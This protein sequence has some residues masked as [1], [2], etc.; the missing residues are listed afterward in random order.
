MN[1]WSSG[2]RNIINRVK[3]QVIDVMPSATLKE[4]ES[5]IS[6]FK[7]IDEILARPAENRILMGNSCQ[8]FV[9]AE[10]DLEVTLMLY[11]NTQNSQLGNTVKHLLCLFIYA[12]FKQLTFDIRIK[13]TEILE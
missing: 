12:C 1:G 10:E 13:S 4:S 2:T 7:K 5:K 8:F 11:R 6:L 9:A 3:Q